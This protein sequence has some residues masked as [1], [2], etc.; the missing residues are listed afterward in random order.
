MNL[1]AILALSIIVLLTFI[2]FIL[3]PCIQMRDSKTAATSNEVTQHPLPA[4][5]FNSKNSARTIV[6]S[7]QSKEFLEELGFVLEGGC[8]SRTTQEDGVEFIDMVTEACVA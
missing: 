5:E 1:S 2:F 3:I 6:S 8:Y 7:D 4:L